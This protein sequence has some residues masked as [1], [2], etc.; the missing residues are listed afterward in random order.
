MIRK[1]AGGL[2]VLLLTATATPAAASDL[3]GSGGVGVRGGTLFFTQ[4]KTIT[5]NSQPRLSGDLVLSYAWTDHM[6]ADITVGYGWNRLDTHDPRYYVATVVPLFPIGLRYKLWDGKTMRPYLGA[7]GGLYNWSIL[8]QD[9]GA[10]KDPVTFERLRRVDAGAYGIVGVE[11]Q[12]SK[13]ITAVLDGNY[14]HIFAN[15][16]DRFP[17]GYS[18]AKSYFQF[19]LGVSF[20]FSLSERI[21]TG[22]PG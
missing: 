7:G 20:W 19:R 15:D 11:R 8:T 5:E 9:L 12:L 14:T 22:L 10:A 16:K 3:T 17:T 2:F 4:D 13:H 21:D 6:T 1:L 18:G